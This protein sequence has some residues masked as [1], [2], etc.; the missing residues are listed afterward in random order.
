VPPLLE[1]LGPDALAFRIVFPISS[2]PLTQMPQPS[3]PLIV[4]FNIAPPPSIPPP[5]RVA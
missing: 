4:L 2:V 1:M 5:E 3:L